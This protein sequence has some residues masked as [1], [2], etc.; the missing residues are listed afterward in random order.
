MLHCWDFYKDE[1][2]GKG[3]ASEPL[4]FIFVASLNTEVEFKGR[5]D[6]GS[7]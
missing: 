3:I 1:E 6:F 7:A 5:Q 4:S 2:L